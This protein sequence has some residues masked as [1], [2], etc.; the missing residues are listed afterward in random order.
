[1]VCT[2]AQLGSDS[3]GGG[4]GGGGFGGGGGGFGG[5]DFRRFIVIDET[6]LQGVADITGGQYFRAEN[7]EQLIDIFNNLPTQIVLQ[8]ETLEISVFFAAFGAIFAV[9]AVGLSLAWNRYP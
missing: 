8:K 7:A 4:F 9:A 6:M 2:S 3:F 5:G 1:M